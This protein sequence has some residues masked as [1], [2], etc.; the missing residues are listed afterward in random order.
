MPN[1]QFDIPKMQNNYDFSGQRA[2]QKQFVGDYTSALKGQETLPAMSDRLGTQMELPQLRETAQGYS[3]LG[4]TLSSQIK[5]VPDVVAGTTR[6]SLVTDPQ[7]QRMIQKQQE[8]LLQSLG[9]V[10]QLGEMAGQRVTQAENQL[11]IQM[12][13]AQTQQQR[14]MQPWMMQYDTMNVQQA[15][16][17]TGWTNEMS[18]E[19]NRLLANQSAGVTLSE[20]EANRMHEL[21]VQENGFNNTIEKLEKTAKMD[22]EL[23]AQTNTAFMNMLKVPG[24]INLF[25]TI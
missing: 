17:M 1:N 7:R 9:E 13:L 15:R 22:Q 16:E 25:N 2:E 6:E 24:G 4:N 19:L 18:N 10:G 14:D 11:G 20:G 12:G 21:S 8:P 5:A 23:V 3:E